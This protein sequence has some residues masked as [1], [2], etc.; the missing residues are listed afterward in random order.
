ML[1]VRQY[2]FPTYKQGQ[3]AVEQYRN[4]LLQRYREGRKLEYEELD[5]LDWAELTLMQKPRSSVG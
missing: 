2:T 3:S 5:W 4:E 1:Q